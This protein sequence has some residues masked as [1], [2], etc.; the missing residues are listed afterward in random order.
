MTARPMFC[1]GLTL[2]VVLAL[3][4][5]SRPAEHFRPP[6][7]PSAFV[8]G[9]EIPTGDLAGAAQSAKAAMIDNPFEGRQTAV[10][11]GKTLFAQMNC[12]GCHGYDLAGAM[13]PDLTDRYWR[14]GGTPGAIYQSI[15]N[16]R[17][18][19]MPAW[20]QALPPADI[21]MLVSY[22]QSHGGVTPTAGYQAGEQGDVA[23]RPVT[24]ATG[25]AATSAVAKSAHP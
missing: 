5:C 12:A 18:Q 8:E 1:N 4:G 6:A 13:G 10:A 14:Y 22:I 24:P 19:G 3:A 2:A 20:R 21:W 17:P 23:A 16:G 9:A 15:A 25:A 11:Q 7:P